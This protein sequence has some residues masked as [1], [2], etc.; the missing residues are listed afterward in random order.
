VSASTLTDSLE[1]RR[2]RG[3]SC[4]VPFF[5]GGYPDQPTFRGLLLEAQARGADAVEI[6]MPFSDPSADGPVIQKTSNISLRSGTTFSTIFEDLLHARADGLTL[7]VVLM[8]YLNPVLAFGPARLQTSAKAAGVDALLVVDLPPAEADNILGP[9]KERPLEQIVM[10]APTTT[11]ERLPT[12]LQQAGGFVYCVALAGVTGA[13]GASPETAGAI[14]AR[15]RPHCGLPALVGFGVGDAQAARRMSS[16]SDGVIV[17]SALLA[18]LG[19]KRG[20]PALRTAGSL[21]AGI[22]SALDKPE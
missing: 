2:S 18:A 6:G 14:V 13:A 4:L 16:V 17:G 9:K 12:I 21:L 5:T 19:E 3:Q 10:V 11:D 15:V 1:A 22:R 8:T 20:R 7:P